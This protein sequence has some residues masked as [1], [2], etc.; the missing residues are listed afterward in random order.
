METNSHISRVIAFWFLSVIHHL[1]LTKMDDARLA[2]NTVLPLIMPHI[3][4]QI[5]Q[6]TETS[7]ISFKLHLRKMILQASHDPDIPAVAGPHPPKTRNRAF[8]K[9]RSGK[10]NVSKII[11]IWWENDIF[12]SSCDEKILISKLHY[13]ASQQAVKLAQYLLDYEE[14]NTYHHATWKFLV[15]VVW[16]FDHMPSGHCA[17]FRIWRLKFVHSTGVKSE[18]RELLHYISDLHILR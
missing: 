17:K 3:L 12:F 2:Y 5:P 4:H 9:S 1:V 8:N 11:G 16:N 14:G 13:N 6:R 7:H 10:R 15:I 18:Y